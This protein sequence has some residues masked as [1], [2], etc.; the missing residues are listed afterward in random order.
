MCLLLSPNLCAQ[1][2]RE[3]PGYFAIYNGSAAAIYADKNDYMVVRRTAVMLRNDIAAITGTEPKVGSVPAGGDNIIVIGSIDSSALIKK[4]IAAKKLDVSK[5]KGR[6]EAYQMQVVKAPFPG[7]AR[8]LVIVGS[9]RRGTAYGV[10]ELSR[11]MGVSP[12]NWWADVPIPRKE[13]LYVRD[14]LVVNEPKVKYRGIFI[15]DEAPALSGWSKEKFGGFNHLFYQKV[16][17]LMLRLRANY[18]WPAMWGNAFYDD[19]S[20]NMQMAD[21]YGIVI[22]TSHHEP[23]MRAHDEW[24]RYGKGKWDYDSNE[25][26]LKD[27]WR[28]GL[29][30][31]GNTE[32]I[33][34]IGMRGDGDAP[35]AQGTAIALLERI[36]QDQRKIIEAV[37][38][39]P[40]SETPQL[41]ALYS[42]A[43]CIC[44]HTRG[45][46]FVLIHL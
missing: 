1:T 3:R 20:L 6:W 18:L 41:W 40:A 5:I 22:G 21:D 16:F 31:T 25:V 33:V 2:G 19:D 12:W 38:Q 45:M 24:R 32:K 13:T 27:F 7:I 29:Q 26:R 42:Q 10:M 17:E 23:L 28:S 34:S 8:A 43:K 44:S 9:N 37:T 36:V 14:S 15:N 11:Q 46:G 4:L 35:M 39:K 30:R